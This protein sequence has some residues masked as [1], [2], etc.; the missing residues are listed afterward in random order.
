MARSYINPDGGDRRFR[1]I[2]SL[3]DFEDAAR[4]YLPGPVFGYVSGAAEENR[5]LAGNRAAF[6]DYDLVPRVLRDVSSRSLE[7][8]LFGETWSAPFG[9]APVALAALA[10]YRGDVSMARAAAAAGIPSVLSGSSLTPLEEVAAAAPRSWFQAYLPGDEAEI[11]GLV[12]RAAAA[13]Y[14]TLVITVDVP[15]LGNREN[16]IRAGFSTPIR[17]TL[18]LALQGL[19]RPRWLFGHFLRTLATTGMP[20]FENSYARRGAPIIARHILRD[21]SGRA[22][23]NWTH[24]A[25]IRRIWEGKLVV[26]GILH[27][28]DARVARDHGADGIA[29]SNHGG[30][31]LDGAIAPLRALPGIVAAVPDLPVMMDSGIRRGTDVIK[32]LALGAKFVFLGRPFVYAAAVGGEDGAAHA[33]G[34]LTDELDR[35]LAL[36]GLNSVSEVT[37]EVL[38]GR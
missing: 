25:L 1:N 11:E 21:F 37:G 18:R 4:R 17:P 10:G 34:I 7:T 27:P 22:H 8:E 5:A 31:Q 19:T 23:L 29:V 13:G 3:D 26:K 28:D 15:V 14:E 35:N 33:I 30:R 9:M 16:L 38:A 2:L 6:T 36:L 12:R 20:H 32:A 24:L